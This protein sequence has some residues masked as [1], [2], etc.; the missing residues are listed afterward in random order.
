[1]DLFARDLKITVDD[2]TGLP[3]ELVSL[4]DAYAMNWIRG[5]YPWGAVEGFSRLKTD[6]I[7]GGVWH[8]GRFDEYA[9]DQDW[10]LYYAIQ[11]LL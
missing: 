8:G 10:A 6:V 9:N 11:Y 2:A 4:K 5:D 1:M 3:V 7:D